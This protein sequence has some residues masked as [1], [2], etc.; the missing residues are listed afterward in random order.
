MRCYK[1][2]RF[3]AVQ[4]DAT[5]YYKLYIWFHYISIYSFVAM[6]LHHPAAMQRYK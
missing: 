2:Y 4:L 6:F 5:P 1:S 3:V